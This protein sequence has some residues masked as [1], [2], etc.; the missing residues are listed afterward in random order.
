MCICI[1]NICN[2]LIDR[3]IISDKLFVIYGTVQNP[4]F[5]AKDVAEWIEMDSSNASR[6]VN[7]V[8]EDEKARH[9]T[10]TIVNLN[11]SL[12][13]NSLFGLELYFKLNYNK[14]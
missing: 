7:S 11:I 2:I 12:Q 3:K 9:I 5:K 6:L 10:T 13:L 1:V 4:W 14:V 8:D